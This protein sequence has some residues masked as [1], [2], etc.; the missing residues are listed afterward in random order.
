MAR[1]KPRSRR[2]RRARRVLYTLAAGAAILV[3][4][5]GAVYRYAE[6]RIEPLLSSD[7]QSRRSTRVFSAPL[8]L[9]N[10]QPRS[11][12]ELR[13]R[14]ER[15][16]YRP[17][18]DA[19]RELTPGQYRQQDG[20]FE[21]FARAFQH[22]LVRAT[23]VHAVVEIRHDRIAEL[24]LA[25]STAPLNELVLEPE[26]LYEISGPQRIRRDPLRF[27]DV[28]ADLI[29]ALIA[30]EDRRFYD[31]PG[32]DVRG[33][34]R[35]AWR[36]LRAGRIEEGGS[37]L[38]QQL[39][40]NLFL[41]P[42]RTF[43]R[44]LKEALI[45]LYLEVRFTKR[46]I[47]RIYLDSVYFGQNGPVSIIGLPA[48][49]K[50][51]FNA[52]P[53]RL[54]L[55]QCALLVGLLRSP[56]GYSPFLHPDRA[57]QRRDLVLGAMRR[58]GF[59]SAAQE[60]GA[61]AEPLGV[62]AAGQRS[63]RDSDYFMAYIQ[64]QLEARYADSA[65]LTRGLTL[66]TTLD[67][68]LQETAREVFSRAPRQAAL[69]ALD[70]RTGA[71]RALIGGRDF[72]ASPFD[73]ATVAMRQPGS[74]FKPFVYGAALQQRGEPGKAW[75][76]SSLLSDAT[77][78][79]RVDAGTWTPRNYSRTY[80]G[81]VPL[82]TA[83]GHSL[84]A[85]TVNLAADIGPQAVIDYARSLGIHSPLRPE[86]GL[87]LGAFEVTLLEITGA[88]CAFA[89]GGFRVDPFGIETVLNFAGEVLETRSPG[90]APVLSPG[91]AYLMTSLLRDAVVDGT[92]RSL[93]RWNLDGVSAGKT[94]TTNDGKDAWFIGYTPYLV[95]GVW[96]GSD[97]PAKLGLTGASA[98]LP[99]WA[100]FIQRSRR[101]PVERGR[102]IPLWPR[103]EDVRTAKLDPETG[104]LARSGCPRQRVEI[105]LAGTVPDAYCPL[106]SGGL[107]GWF[108]K[109]FRRET[110]KIFH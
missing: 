33:I 67:P 69:A 87:A 64:R 71:V 103:P 22:P 105:F 56:N 14:L 98:A 30:I 34:A 79:F 45:A 63:P 19:G 31:H 85:A 38:T 49:A 27:A 106:H 60:R 70:P 10:G 88:Y 108:R 23:P 59:I 28:P 4:A 104:L 7:W 42:R 72:A 13:R 26:L 36:N 97:I 107:V 37:T 80:R 61:L 102:D 11:I 12:R 17:G 110:P 54:S 58:D 1:R 46:D 3:F 35:A 73:R 91:E 83:L 75:T 18:G 48:A 101:F 90:P 16:D 8:R 92:A 96:T 15:L 95:A 20:R 57:R 100:N 6:R 44:K 9:Q 21:V 86:L 43:S 41:S 55:A 52:A 47:L 82:R 40:R 94:G 66:Y 53:E 5:A 68:W 81:P 93:S 65:L 51:L 89:N 84:N 77:R 62:T 25:R 74:A 109:I 99:L 29:E 39:A 32:V 78:T 2:P 50:H 24:A 76:P